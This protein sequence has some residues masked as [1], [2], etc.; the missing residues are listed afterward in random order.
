VFCRLPALCF[1]S[2]F[3]RLPNETVKLLPLT[4]PSPSPPYLLPFRNVHTRRNVVF[5]PKMSS[6]RHASQH[7]NVWNGMILGVSPTT[8][9]FLFVEHEKLTCAFR[10]EV[11]FQPSRVPGV[12]ATRVGYSGLEIP[13]G[14]MF[15]FFLLFSRLFVVL[16]FRSRFFIFRIAPVFR[17]V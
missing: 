1:R 8:S 2:V 5:R 7:G 13:F 9:F 3:F 6:N 17:R 14:P 11:T 16:V 4:L 12:I 15:F 10:P